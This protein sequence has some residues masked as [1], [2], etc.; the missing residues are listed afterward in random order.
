MKK[1]C[2]FKPCVLSAHD[3]GVSVVSFYGRKGYGIKMNFQEFSE[4]V[5]SGKIIKG[6][7]E[8]HHYLHKL[9]QQALK[10]TTEI[11][12]SFHDEKELR[13]LFSKLI[14]KPVDE[15]FGLHPPFHTDCGKN[16][17]LGKNVFI[18][19][20]CHFQDQGGITIG[21]GSLIGHNVVLATL[22]HAFSPGN[23]AD[24]QP[25]PIII[26][27]RVWIG[28]SSTVLP[29]ISIGDN[30]IIG[31]GSV[32]TKNVPPNTIAAGNPARIIKKID[33]YIGQ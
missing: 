29:G 14:G 21:D 20:G 25:K 16:I 33:E 7:S 18:N 26:G 32:V 22:N 19:S 11:N 17:T 8:I 1:C 12:N 23:R 6:G 30:A 31:A 2:D 3:N 4:Y 24:M 13:I 5:S 15:G 28:S 10:I 27:K 9:S